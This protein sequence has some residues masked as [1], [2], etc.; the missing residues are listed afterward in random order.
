MNSRF[1]VILATMK[2]FETRL[3]VLSQKVYSKLLKLYKFWT[4]IFEMSFDTL[5][6]LVFV[7][8]FDFLI[9][10]KYIIGRQTQIVLTI[11]GSV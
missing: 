3:M 2:R 9:E 11:T 10:V 1:C 6:F 5:A 4:F 7:S 8:D